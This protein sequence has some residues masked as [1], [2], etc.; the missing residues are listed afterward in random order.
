MCVGINGNDYM[1]TVTKN[2]E[3]SIKCYFG[4]SPGT[5]PPVAKPPAPSTAAT[6]LEG[7]KKR[8]PGNQGTL[9]TGPGGVQN[10]TSSKT[11]LGG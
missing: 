7:Q 8:R 3:D 10:Q 2:I 5:P 11:I 6:N 4:G 9:L 1:I